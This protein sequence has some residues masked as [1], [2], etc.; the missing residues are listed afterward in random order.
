MIR[1][2]FGLGAIKVPM[3]IKISGRF[4]LL[5]LALLTFLFLGLSRCLVLAESNSCVECHAKIGKSDPSHPAHSFIE[6]QNSIHAKKGINCDAC[7]GGNP[8]SKD[9]TLAHKNISRS[10][11]PGSSIYFDKIPDSCGSCHV[12]EL[13]G[14]K[15]SDHYKELN[16]SGKGPNCVTCHSSMASHVMTPRELESVC[17]LCHRRPTKAYAA[18]LSLQS[19]RKAIDQ[20][21]NHIQE[22]KIKKVETEAQST[23]L[24]QSE[25][26][27]QEAL[28]IWHT[29]NM[30]KVLEVAQELNHRVRNAMHEL[31]LKG[32]GIREENPQRK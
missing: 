16:R 15:S 6:W 23:T 30:E 22:A 3:A 31:D 11:D 25:K 8:S 9:V 32:Q 13:E 29:F 4:K 24:I 14:F 1:T 12:Q 20:L 26:N 21:R 17:T 10:M 2:N 19:S 27:Y 18:L 28:K 5:H 7:H